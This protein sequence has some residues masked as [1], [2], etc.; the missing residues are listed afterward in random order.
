M[1]RV[2]FTAVAVVVVA[3]CA[4]RPL[5]DTPSPFDY[6]PARWVDLPDA[7]FV[8]R[9][10][11][12]KALLVARSK[13]RFTAIGIG[14]VRRNRGR[15][16]VIAELVNLFVSHGFFGPGWPVETPFND[17]NN[18]EL[19]ADLNRKKRCPAESFL[20]IT[21]AGGI[22]PLWNAEGTRWPHGR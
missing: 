4:H 16:H 9:M 6:I 17:L 8:A 3:A 18:P 12:H 19:Y 10:R 7:P 22:G 15:T 1:L 14:C 21:S 11:G 2:I 5:G 20:A 13:D